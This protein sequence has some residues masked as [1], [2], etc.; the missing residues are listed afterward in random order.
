M[1]E[2]YSLPVNPFHHGFLCEEREIEN[3]S[4]RKSCFTLIELLVVVAIIAV[5]VAMLLPALNSARDSARRIVCASNLREIAKAAS[6]YAEDSGYFPVQSYADGGSSYRDKRTYTVYRLY[7]AGYLK[8]Y[9]IWYCPSKGSK[10]ES[11]NWTG[12]F[13]DFADSSY[14]YNHNFFQVI[15]N[16][17]HAWLCAEGNRLYNQRGLKPFV[18]NMLSG[19]AEK[20]MS[21]IIMFA[22]GGYIWGEDEIY[23]DFFWGVLL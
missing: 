11:T 9:D 16:W 18:S 8:D 19:R 6:Y 2:R 12:G 7:H 23:W 15:R 10:N 20:P 14:L 3:I 5:L 13:P 22:D 17:S 1:W 4:M 21:Q